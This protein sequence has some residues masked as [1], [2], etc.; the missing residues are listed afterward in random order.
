MQKHVFAHGGANAYEGMEMENGR[1]I[2]SFIVT[3]GENMK[4]KYMKD[5]NDIFLTFQ[6]VTFKPKSNLLDAITCK[7]FCVIVSCEWMRKVR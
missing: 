6:K 3:F 1:A 2:M 4:S 7:A 5:E